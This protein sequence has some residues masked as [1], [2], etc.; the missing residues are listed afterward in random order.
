VYW[1]SIY[2]VRFLCARRDQIKRVIAIE[3]TRYA[4]DITE[5]ST[6]FNQS[7]AKALSVFRAFS[8]RNRTMTLAEIAS[9]ADITRSSAQRIIFTLEKLGYIRKHPRTRRF[10]LTPRAVFLGCGYL[11]S[12]QLIDCANPFLASLGASSGETVALTEPDAND[13]VYVARFPSHKHITIHV[14]LGHRLPMYCTASGRA[15]LSGRPPQEVEELLSQSD[16]IAHT[17]KTCTDLTTLTK[18]IEQARMRGYTF[19]NE[20]V[21]IGDIGIAAPIINASGQSIA[22]VHIEAPGSRWTFNDAVQKLAPLV[23][24]CA[25]SISN[26]ARNLD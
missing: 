5:E 3:P 6:L 8:S 4:M 10:Q 17:T 22:S 24:D 13:M 2:H 12:D 7:L 1:N 15:Y 25:R 16:R 18:Y 23:I 21:Y 20:E 11:E 26:A 19:N 9:S 14:T